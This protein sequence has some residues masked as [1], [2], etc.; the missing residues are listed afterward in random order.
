MKVR[1]KI[2]GI[3]AV[4]GVA[5]FAIAGMAIYATMEYSRLTH[6]LSNADDRALYGTQLNRLVTAVVMESRGIYA[7]P[8][9]A[10][11]E[12]FAKNLEKRL[13][14]IDDLFVVWEKAI[15][16]DAK[17]SFNALRAQNDQF[18]EFR[19]ELVRL[20]REESTAAANTYGNNDANRTN[21]AGYQKEIDATVQRNL[22]GA[23]LAENEMNAFSNRIGNWVIGTTAAGLLIGIAIALY[24]GTAQLS[25]PLARVSAALQSIGRGDYNVSIPAKRSKDEIGDIWNVLGSVT[26]SLKETEALKL[27]QVEAEQR[28]EAEKRALMHKLAD[29]FESEVMGVVRA[30]SS[31]ATQ[32]QQNATQMSAVADE[33][34][35]Q[36]TVVAAAS[37]E[38]T[39]NVETVAGAA[40]E[41]SASIREISGQVSTAA[42]VAGEASGQAKTTAEV[43][44]GLASSA[45]RIGEVVG[46][47]N[48][49]AAQTNLLALNATIEAARAG[50]AGK[51]FAV[52]ASEVKN[53][54]AQTAKAT[55]EIS[56]QIQD[57]QNATSN[58]VGAINSI[59]AIIEQV[60]EISNTIAAAVDQ[61]GAATTEIARNVAQAAAGT[62]EVTSNITG[63]SQAAAETENVSGQ[64][65]SAANDL[66]RQ[67]ET[68]RSQVDSFIQ[69][70]RAA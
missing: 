49:I 34:S 40:E 5:A 57:V 47:I 14:E 66:S 36:S 44:S 2:L 61:Q 7:A 28:A 8:D 43:V 38:A 64:I 51:G 19:L 41:L 59:T 26:A 17:D 46:L 25:R 54:A 32:L 13:A 10:A 52:V 58:V 33:T 16:A 31:A 45:Q 42:E 18:K 63:V 20:A 30:V 69:R 9:K 68:L 4:M 11:A 37:E 12:P 55:D 65:V 15:P 48:D 50:E 29:D 39:T 24:I 22:D 53:L 1:T 35:R 21:R 23:D 3:V 60:N 67:S 56:S 62:G 27:A 6:Q 70:V